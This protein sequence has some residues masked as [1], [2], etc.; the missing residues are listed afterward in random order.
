MALTLSPFGFSAKGEKV[1]AYTLTNQQ[2]ASVTWLNYGATIQSLKIPHPNGTPMDVVL[3]YSSLRDYEQNDGNMGATI[4]RVANRIGNG[5][6]SLNQKT[7][8]LAKNASPHHLHGGNIGFDKQ[9]WQVDAYEDYLQAHLLSPDGDEGYPG[10]LSVCLTVALLEDNTLVLRYCA[11]TTQDTPVNLTN[12]SYFNLHGKGSVAGHQLLIPAARYC[13]I[14]KTV[15]PTGRIVPVENTPLDFR[16]FKD[17]DAAWN[18]DHPQIHYGGGYDHNFVLDGSSPI[19]L[20]S[21]LSGL[22]MTVNTDLPGVQLYT[23]NFLT[24]R[25]GKENRILAPRYGV[26]LETQLFPDGMAHYGFPSPILRAGESMTTE[27][28]Y[29]FRIC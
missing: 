20:Y 27:T 2:G 29:G 21:P 1:T 18:A 10:D 7:Y 26:C 23:A 13:E 17:V 28:R 11:T 6:F 4:G 3:G 14:D 22:E 5:T 24:P 15:L 19:R 12:H 16:S 9:I 8:Q 25:R